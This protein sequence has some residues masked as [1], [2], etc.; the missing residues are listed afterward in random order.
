MKKFWM[1]GAG[2]LSFGLT[3]IPALAQ[4]PIQRKPGDLPGPIDSIEDLQDTGRMLFKL[5]DENNDGQ[6]SQQEA[7]DAGNLLVGGFFFRADKNGDGVLSPD[8]AKAA[9]DAF[10]N[11]KPWVRYAIGTA[12]AQLAKDGAT[13]NNNR[14]MLA[15][16]AGT[17]DSN[18]DKQLQASELRQAVQT[19]IQGGFATADTNR[20]GQLSPAEVNASLVAVGRQIAQASFQ[21]ADSDNDGQISQAEFMKAIEEPAKVAF[22]IMDLN[23]DGKISPQEAQTARQMVVSKLRQGAIREPSNSPRNQI[24]R[25]IGSQNQPGQA[26]AAPPQP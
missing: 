19:A 10:L 21:Q 12:K 16:L 2:A 8:E 14:N 22:A 9:R 3:I 6:I 11:S 26:P 7:V 24:N 1:L 15:S 13:K 4:E 23:H 5:A 18:N 17:F 20:D 25:A